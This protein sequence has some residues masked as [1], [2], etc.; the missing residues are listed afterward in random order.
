MKTNNTDNDRQ[1]SLCGGKTK[2]IV[3]LILGIL[4]ISSTAFGILFFVLN[5]PEYSAN[6]LTG[7]YSGY[8]WIEMLLMAFINI[9]LY[10]SFIFLLLS[11]SCA[12][13]GL[14]FSSKA[15]RE[16]NNRI[17]KTAL[18]LN[19]SSL[20]LSGI[21]FVWLA[22]FFIAAFLLNSS[23]GGFPPALLYGGNLYVRLA[24]C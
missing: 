10:F 8:L 23:A 2:G 24:C 1:R 12:V 4:S 5:Y 14:I 13:P 20:I 15:K 11:F 18:I 21:V 19:M 3:G 17:P 9:R 7:D 6:V 16:N 22:V